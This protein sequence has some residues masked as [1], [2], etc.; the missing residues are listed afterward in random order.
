MK[1]KQPIPV[2][3]IAKLIDAEVLGDNSAIVTGINEIHK[4]EN[5]DLTF[6]DVQKYF[7]KSLTSAASFVIL[8]ERMEC[9]EGKVLLLHKDPFSAYNFLTQHFRPFEYIK[10]EV[11]STAI[12]GEGTILEPNVIIGEYVKIGKNSLIRA[13]T[14]VHAHTTI[15]DHVIIHSNSVIGSDAFYYKKRENG[16]EKWHSCGRVIIED[17]V[18]IGALVTIDKG[19]SGDTIIGAGSKIDNH[20]HIAHGVVVGKNCLFAAQVGIAGKTTIENGVTLLGQAGVSTNLTIGQGAS[21]SAQSGVSKSLDGGK[22]YFGSP[23][24]P[25]MQHHRQMASLRGLPDLIKRLEQLEKLLISQ[26]TE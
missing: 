18:E 17:H 24:M 22:H 3:E 2:S 14:V 16:F 20:C 26:K 25:I 12:I 19:V 1:L 13:N 5:G 7:K 9:P 8:N 4:V 21:I 23:A 6:V 11:A 15:G 10:N